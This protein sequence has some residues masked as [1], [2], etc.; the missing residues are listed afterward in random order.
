[1]TTRL[2]KPEDYA[3]V[4]EWFTRHGSKA[5]P[6]AVL[7]RCGVVV[8]EESLPL[9]AAW[10]YQDNSVGVAWLA[11]IVT[12][13]DIPAATAVESLNF[14]IRAS[15]AVAKGLGYG[16]MFTMT[17]KPALGRLLQRQGFAP[18]HQGMTQYFKPLN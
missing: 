16:V 5:V 8:M 12:N 10:I 9:A 15:E 13:S 17:E 18:N 1:M 7:P 14:L 4:S 11:W 2:Y 3:T 6:E